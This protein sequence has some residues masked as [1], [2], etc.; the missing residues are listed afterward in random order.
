M[1]HWTFIF[2]ILALVAGILGFSSLAGGAAIVAQVLCVI[3]LILMM[4]STFSGSL[5]GKAH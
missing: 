3:F 1:Y 4:V 2:L 5:G